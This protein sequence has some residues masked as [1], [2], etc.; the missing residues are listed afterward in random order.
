MTDFLLMADF[1]G[2][3][4][5]YGVGDIVPRMR[6]TRDMRPWRVQFP[7]EQPVVDDRPGVEHDC[8]RGG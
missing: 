3:E 4:V 1:L 5:D 6:K 8:A 7:C 2:I